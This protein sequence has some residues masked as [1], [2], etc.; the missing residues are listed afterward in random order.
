MQTTFALTREDF[1]LYQQLLTRRL[2]RKAKAWKLG[3]LPF[4]GFL[5]LGMA[6]GGLLPLIA[7]DPDAAGPL[8]AACALL[9]LGMLALMAAAPVQKAL[10]RTEMLLPGGAFL[11]DTT[12]SVSDNGMVLESNRCRSELAWSSFLEA[13]QDDRNHY[14]FVDAMQAVV[15]P[16]AAVAAFQPEFEARVSRIGAPR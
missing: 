14:L 5:L 2:R 4:T 1:G 12:M 3:V 11:S 9:V 6:A 15:V 7:R 10:L 8:Q 16:K 13:V